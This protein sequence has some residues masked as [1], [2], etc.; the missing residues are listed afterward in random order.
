MLHHEKFDVFTKLRS[1]FAN[2]RFSWIGSCEDFCLGYIT[3][4]SVLHAEVDTVCRPVGSFVIGHTATGKTQFLEALCQLFPQQRIINLTTASTKSLIYECRNN[5]RYLNGK[6]VFVEELSGIKNKEI[7]YLLRVLLTKGYAVHNTVLSGQA[8]NIEIHGAI[9]LQ[10]TGLSTDILRDDT[11]NRLVIF[12]S[13]DSQHRTAA[14]I[15]NII[16]RYTKRSILTSDEFP[17]Y[18]AFFASLKAYPVIIPYGD[19]IRFDTKNFATRRSSKIFMD[20]LSAVTLINQH[21]RQIEDSAVVSEFADFELLVALTNKPRKPPEQLLAP[22]Q[23]SI[24]KAIDLVTDKA[25]FTYQDVLGSKPC[26]SNGEPYTLSSIKKAM[27]KLRSLGLVNVV[28]NS[29]PAYFALPKVPPANRFGVV[30]PERLS[31]S[32]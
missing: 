31:L 27:F 24:L 13:D 22:P 18:L 7:Q 17:D 5:S 4:A 16:D 12:E 2:N 32:L 9:S 20:L 8:E 30:W 26:G 3:F 21:H 10:S 6:I 23:V 15:G 25:R 14:V 19:R 11:M 1:D 28:Q 29:R